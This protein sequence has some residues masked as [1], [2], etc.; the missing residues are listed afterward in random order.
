MSAKFDGKG[1]YLGRTESLSNLGIANTWT[2]GFWTKPQANKEHSIIFA[3]GDKDSLNEIQVFTTAIPAETTVHGKRPS[4]LRAIV[5]DADGTTIKHYGWPN[6][7]QTEVWTHT[8]L[9]WNGVELEAFR[10]AYTTTTGVALV[11]ATGTMT[12]TVRKMYY[13]S[14]VA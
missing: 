14:A 4:E 2:L 12:D 1:Q 9:Q 5:K 6:W 3:V 10:D 13:G 7:F 11:N 8:F